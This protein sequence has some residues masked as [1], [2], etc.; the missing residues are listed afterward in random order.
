MN[1]ILNKTYALLYLGIVIYSLA[2]V[3][4]KI[5]AGYCIFSF[6]WFFFYGLGII[7]M[8]VYA[9][10]WQQ[11]LKYI[12]LTTAYANRAVVT[13]L[14]LLWGV[15]FFGEK[16]SLRIIMGAIITVVGVVVITGDEYGE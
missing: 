6:N 9:I 5:A 2:S 3:F 7:A 14:G 15:V 16:I 8:C 1:K 10:I 13:V 12:P 4:S 11:I